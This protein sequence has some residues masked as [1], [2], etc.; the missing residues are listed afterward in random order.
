VL[1]G[2]LVPFVPT[3]DL[4]RQLLGQRA[5]PETCRCLTEAAGVQLQQLH[6]KD[7]ALTPAEL[8][9]WDFTVP[10]QDAQSFPGTVAYLGLDAFAVPIRAQPGRDWKMLYVGVLYDPRKE[11]TLYL[12]DYDFEHVAG[13]LRRYAVTL[14]MGR[15][16]TFVALTDGGNGLERVLHQGVGG[17]VVCVLDW[18]H[19]SEKLHDLGGL[20]HDQDASAATAWARAREKTLWEQGG[21]G[22]V[23]EL[24]QLGC[25]ATAAPAAQEKWTEVS[26]HVQ[27][28]GHRTAYPE[29]RAKGWDVGSGPVEAGCKVLSG[30]VKGTGMRWEQ[31]HSVEVAAL[32][33]LYA[34]GMG[35]WEAFWAQR[36]PPLRKKSHPQ[37]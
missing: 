12:V 15:A 33:A 6:Q 36:Q 37:K 23:A 22:L 14:G 1:L 21:Q 16:D 17:A 10:D 19:L 18:W 28:N 2:A 20:L 3:S 13:L 30:R 27:K 25:P 11:H 29:Y 4:L 31:T 34:S 24:E 9:T 8:P 32:K 7:Q 5:A 26:H 35:L